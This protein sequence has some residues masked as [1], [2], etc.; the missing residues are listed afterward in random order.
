MRVAIFNGPE[1]PITIEQVP[2]PQPG[3]DDVLLKVGRCGICGSDIAMTGGG[4]FGFPAG[5]TLGHEYAGE[6]VECGRNITDVKVGDRVACI[7]SIG[8]GQCGACAAG[9]YL[10][11]TASRPLFGGFGDYVAAPRKNAVVLPRSLSESDGALVE[12]MACGLHALTMARIAKGDSLLVLGAGSMANA[13]VYWA[14]RL[15][16]GRIVV[17]SRSA[18]RRDIAMAMGADAMH[19]FDEDA[20]DA[21]AAIFGGMPDIVAECVGKP[22][23]LNLAI[24]HVRPG[25][26]VLCMGMCMLPEA[27]VAAR[28]TFKEVS[29]LFPL[30]YSVAEFERT[31]RAFDAGDIRPDLMV[32]DVIALEELPAAMERIRAGAKCHKVHVDPALEHVHA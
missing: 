21:L 31:A 7:P 28:C 4:P 26:T 27:L 10:S 18:H 8:C 9:L 30:G 23:M 3:A 17:A 32:S 15:G 2:V 11:C 12:P 6:V 13:M 24:D 16:A 22:D 20:P 29:L 5:F 19:S 25:G 1:R 14:R